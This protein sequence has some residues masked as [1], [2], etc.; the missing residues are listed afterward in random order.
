MQAELFELLAWKT[1]IADTDVPSMPAWMQSDRASLSA[2][3]QALPKRE[4]I[5]VPLKEQLVVE[6]YSR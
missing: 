4:E 3:I 2:T 5:E 1:L 6:Y